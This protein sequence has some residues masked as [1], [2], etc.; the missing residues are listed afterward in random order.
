MDA[1]EQLKTE[2]VQ[3]RLVS[4]PSWELFD[5]QPRAYRDSV[6]PPGIPKVAVEAGVT[7]AWGRYLDGETDNVIG[8]DRF[9][10]SAPYKTIFE[11]YGLTADR[12]AEKA[13]SLIE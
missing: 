4:M 3:A 12:V 11:Q 7:L 1:V 9:G 10:A 5:Q 13:K 6:L 2:G 8:V